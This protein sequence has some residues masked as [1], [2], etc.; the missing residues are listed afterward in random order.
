MSTDW[1]ARVAAA[2][3][4]LPEAG[5]QGV[6]VPGGLVLTVA[7]ALPWEGHGGMALGDYHLVTVK[8]KNGSPF[9]LSIYCVEPVSDI[10]VLGEPDTQVFS[11]DA[12]M[13]DA[14]R[15][16]TASIG[17]SARDFEPFAHVPVH[18]LTHHG[19]WL[20]G[21][22]IDMP[23]PDGC[24]WLEGKEQIEG[25]TSGGPVVDDTGLLIG[26]VSWFA[27]G[28]ESLVR[29]GRMPRPHRALPSWLW[30]RI[31]ADGK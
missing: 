13:F 26:L 4:A 27:E 21:K 2:T 3:I 12:Q 10:A 6:L 19:T 20:E 25:G 1:R 7:H 30:A 17:V 14:F 31:Q 15:E 18:V 22:G 16:S 23:S 24:G 9:R 8:P 29:D 5:G 11:Q 28:S